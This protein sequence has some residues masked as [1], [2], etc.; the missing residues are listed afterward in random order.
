MKVE[1]KQQW[2]DALR[3]GKYPQ[4][5]FSLKNYEGY[6]CLGVLCDIM[7]PNGWSKDEWRCNIWESADGNI[8]GIESAFRDDELLLVGLS[9]DE[10]FTLVNK[11][12]MEKCSFSEIAN[13]IE[14]HVK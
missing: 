10:Q 6:C 3:S 11:N 7:N 12:D 8:K 5:R 13:Y 1:L 9:K 4:A 14:E 2:I